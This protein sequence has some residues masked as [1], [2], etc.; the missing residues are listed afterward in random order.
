[1]VRAL[2]P[3][4][5]AL[6]LIVAAGVL[7]AQNGVL[8]GSSPAAPSFTPASAGGSCCSGF[9]ATE[10]A[11]SLPGDEPACCSKKAGCTEG[12]CPSLASFASLGVEGEEKACSAGGCPFG[13]VLAESKCCSG[14][15]KEC[16]VESCKEC[17]ESPAG[18]CS[19][20]GKCCT[21]EAECCEKEQ[22]V[23]AN[24]SDVVA[25]ASQ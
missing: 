20:D 9:K 14:E 3:V 21:S 6:A 22:E 18:C 23:Q 15:A 12:Q 2:L 11:A 10:M 4:T 16:S 8:S 1:M 7:L 19:K 25:A 5:F 24:A 17:E 13:A